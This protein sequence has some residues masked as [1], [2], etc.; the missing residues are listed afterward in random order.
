VSRTGCTTLSIWYILKMTNLG[1]Q[2]LMKF[3]IIFV[4]EART[5]PF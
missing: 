1:K 2:M 4:M 5:K 3:L